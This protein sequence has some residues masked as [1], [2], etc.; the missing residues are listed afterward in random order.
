M[1]KKDSTIANIRIKKLQAINDNLRTQLN[2]EKMA[3]TTREIRVE[4]LH[5]WI[6]ELGDNPKDEA[7]VQALIK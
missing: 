1:I 7:F 2:N 6:I 4:E 5:K 3:T